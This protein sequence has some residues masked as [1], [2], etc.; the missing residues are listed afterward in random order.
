MCGYSEDRIENILTAII[1]TAVIL[2]IA[3][4]IIT[5]KVQTKKGN[6][7]F[8]PGIEF[9]EKSENPFT[10]DTILVLDKKEN[11][12][13]YVHVKTGEVDTDFIGYAYRHYREKR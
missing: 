10:R 13:K 12:I 4:P 6:I 9:V 8:Q 5:S 7:I 11:Y 1:L 2:C 3:I